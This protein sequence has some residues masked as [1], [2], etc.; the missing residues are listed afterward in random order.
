MGRAARV[1][2]ALVLLGVAASPGAAQDPPPGLGLVD[3]SDGTAAV[4]PVGVVSHVVF[5]ATWCPRCVEELDRLAELEAR[6]AGRGYRLTL[7]AV[8]TRQTPERLVKFA[9]DRDPPGSLLFDP[10]GK[11]QARFAADRLPMHLVLDG[12]GAELLRSSVLDASVE[13][14]IG[15][16]FEAHESGR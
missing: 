5:I 8:G 11:A 6:W 15:D 9:G 10:L 1:L 16:A 3:P 14:A 12:S 7:I 4:L 2:L 13:R